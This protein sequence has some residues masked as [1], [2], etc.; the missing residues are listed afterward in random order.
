M[1]QAILDNA[2]AAALAEDVGLRDITTESVVPAGAW[3]AAAILSREQGVLAG[4]PAARVVFRQVDPVVSFEEVREEGAVIQPGEVVARVEGP[5]RSI[6]TAERTALN[7][8]QRLSGIATMASRCQQACAGASARV[9]DTRKTAPGLR[10]LDKYAVR[11]GGA[12]NHREG[13]FDGVLIK[14]NHI[15]AGGGIARAVASARRNAPHTLRIEVECDTLDEV[16]Q[17]ISAGAEIILLDNMSTSDMREAVRR[18]AGRAVVEASG[19]VTL[20]RIP[21]VASTGVDLISVGALTHSVQ[22]L[23]LSL[24]ITSWRIPGEQ[25]A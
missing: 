15:R 6:L 1:N 2:V 24:E 3:A 18:I 23:D 12:F 16:G 20:D 17:A 4:L 25:A 13:L 8:L 7:F 9:V 14:E 21:E 11:V 10:A 5:A 19:N 22:A